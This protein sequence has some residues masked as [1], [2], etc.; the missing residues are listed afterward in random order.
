MVGVS[1]VKIQTQIVKKEFEISRMVVGTNYTASQHMLRAI[2][3][4]TPS[5]THST[6]NDVIALDFAFSSESHPN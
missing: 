6:N 4:R 1:L 5:R 3:V 2:M